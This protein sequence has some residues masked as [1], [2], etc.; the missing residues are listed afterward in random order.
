MAFSKIKTA[1]HTFHNVTA[2]WHEERLLDDCPLPS[3]LCVAHRNPSYTRTSVPYSADIHLISHAYMPKLTGVPRGW[4]C[5]SDPGDGYEWWGLILRRLRFG[6]QGTSYNEEWVNAE[7]VT[8]HRN[9]SSRYQAWDKTL[10]RHVFP[11][12]TKKQRLLEKKICLI[13]AF[14]KELMW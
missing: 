6:S 2:N 11:G 3:S 1:N 13:M 4:A 9:G 10:N 12:E 5:V 8:D 7:S 14:N